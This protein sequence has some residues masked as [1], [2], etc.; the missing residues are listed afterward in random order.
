M[1]IEKQPQVLRLASLRMT[2]NFYVAL[3][4]YEQ[5]KFK[6]SAPIQQ[7]Q[8]PGL[9]QLPRPGSLGS[10]CLLRAA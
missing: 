9:R 10:M 8:P 7:F 1:L 5:T 2:V 4:R 3:A 6:G